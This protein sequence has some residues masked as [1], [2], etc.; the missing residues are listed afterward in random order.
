MAP[1]GLETEGA[2]LIINPESDPDE[3]RG[4]LENLCLKIKN[5]TIEL[6]HQLQEAGK[7]QPYREQEQ[8]YRQAFQNFTAALEPVNVM[9]NSASS[10][11][12]R[13]IAE[14]LKNDLRLIEA[15]LK[16]IS[17]NHSSGTMS[18]LLQ[19]F[20]PPNQANSLENLVAIAESQL[21]NKR[22]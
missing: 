12:G 1:I 3:E 15:S 2:E 9:A 6:R 21:E 5:S 11:I 14:Q 8:L 17:D 4:L 13:R 18:H 22:V 7:K 16:T 20:T 10:Q 19:Y